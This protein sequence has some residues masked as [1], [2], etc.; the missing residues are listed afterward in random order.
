MDLDG[1]A[2]Q[3][4]HNSFSPR[5]LEALNNAH[6][7][8]ILVVP[9][10][11]RQFG[12]LPG[13][14]K[15]HHP[16]EGYAILCNGGQIRKLHSNRLLHNLEILPRALEQLLALTEEY[17]LPIM[18]MQHFSDVAED[19]Q[20]WANDYL[21]HVQFRSGNTDIMPSSPIEMESL[22]KLKTIPA[23]GSGA[24]TSRNPHSSA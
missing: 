9:V 11:G 21:E 4:D 17:D 1:T 18:R 8:G 16:W 5:L 2:L 15:E 24:D 7:R 23:P 14:L 10:T 22:G 6:D 13:V 3:R 20:A 19:P 12:L